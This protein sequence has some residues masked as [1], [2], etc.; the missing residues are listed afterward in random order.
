MNYRTLISVLILVLTLWRDPGAEPKNA[1]VFQFGPFIPTDYRLQ[2]FVS[3][4]YKSGVG[5]G[6]EI[7]LCPMRKIGPI[8]LRLEGGYRWHLEKHK[9]ESDNISYDG[10]FWQWSIGA[11]SLVRTIDDF[12]RPALYAAVGGAFYS[13]T[14]REWHQL[15]IDQNW[16]LLSQRS[17]ENGFWGIHFM[18]GFDIPIYRR[19]LTQCE[20]K[21]TYS[22]SDWEFKSL[23]S[24]EYNRVYHDVNTGGISLKIGLGYL[25]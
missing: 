14:W 17:M 4:A 23:Q 1:I 7:N 6:L 8:W 5:D 22:P 24:P 18:G 16:I 15:Y 20:L 19:F 9:D 13:A 3:D 21:Y 10:E 2:R 11:S 12:S 25:L